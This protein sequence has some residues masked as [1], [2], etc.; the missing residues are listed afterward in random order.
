MMSSHADE[1]VEDDSDLS[2]HHSH[3][4]QVSFHSQDEKD[5]EAPNENEP[6]DDNDDDEAEVRVGVSGR[7]SEGEGGGEGEGI[8]SHPSEHEEAV[9]AGIAIDVVPPAS[10]PY[11][12]Q[13]HETAVPQTELFEVDRI[14]QLPDATLELIS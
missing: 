2:I 9:D 14:G 7:D 3:L 4:A 6:D 5:D 1:S 11:E 13:A 10:L 12:V 8:R